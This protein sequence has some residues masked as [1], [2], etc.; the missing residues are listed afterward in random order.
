MSVSIS[1]SVSAEVSFVCHRGAVTGDVQVIDQGD[2]GSVCRW[3]WSID[4]GQADG[5]SLTGTGL[6]I[7]GPGFVGHLAA[8]GLAGSP[9][10]QKPPEAP[11]PAPPRLD[12]WTA[13]ATHPMSSSSSPF[14]MAQS[15]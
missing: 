5:L 1:A 12:T 13:A 10:G 11:R 8:Q 2:I 4:T 15:V 3:A 7:S 14:L 9:R 6:W